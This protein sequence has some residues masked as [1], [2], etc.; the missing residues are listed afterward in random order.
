MT[1]W[2]NVSNDFYEIDSSYQMFYVEFTTGSV[3]I[4]KVLPTD[5]MIYS[6]TG[7][8]YFEFAPQHQILTDMIL[9]ITFPL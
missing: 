7:F 6:K 1:S 5:P 8:Y 9:T 3:L 4:K 2:H